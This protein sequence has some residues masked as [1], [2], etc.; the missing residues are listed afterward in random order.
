MYLLFLY[1][2]RQGFL[3]L[4]YLLIH[5]FSLQLPSLTQ[6]APFGVRSACS[7]TAPSYDLLSEDGLRQ[8]TESESSMDSPIFPGK[9][10][11]STYPSL[12]QL[13]A[14][15]CV[16]PVHYPTPSLCGLSRSPLHPIR[17][18]RGCVFEECGFLY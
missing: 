11:L 18:R 17:R 13:G 5:M 8:G 15:L 10:V 12:D 9:S 1:F 14:S 6:V 4:I 16:S 3:F 2:L 7:A